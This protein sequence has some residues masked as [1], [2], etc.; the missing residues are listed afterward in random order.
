MKCRTCSEDVPQK[1]AHAISI[2]CCPLC[3]QQIMLPELQKA[4]NN[5]RSVMS[6]IVSEGF[7]TEAFDWLYSN[8]HLISLESDE[9]QSLQQEV[10]EAKQETETVRQELEKAMNAFVKPTP[11]SGKPH[12]SGAVQM[13]VDEHGEQVQLQGEALQDP[14]RTQSFMNRAQV[15]KMADRNQH[16]KQLASQIRK[17]GSTAAMGESGEAIV[18]TPEMLNSASAEEVEQMEV[19]LSGSLPGVA[20]ALDTGYDDDDALP[21]Q[22]EAFLHQGQQSPDYNPRDVAKLQALHSKSRQASR[23]LDQGGSVGLIKR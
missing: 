9:Y 7:Q 17:T 15:S 10:E 3:G 23:A 6:E 11:K 14:N 18:I 4:L 1:F 20:S 2:N 8:F 19:M 16:L 21:P 13:G 22:V 12:L 5:L